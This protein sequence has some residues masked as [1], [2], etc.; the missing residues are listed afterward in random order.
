MKFENPRTGEVWIC[1]NP[2]NKKVIDGVSFIE[3]HKPDN[4]RRVWINRSI[5]V[6]KK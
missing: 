2:E 1:D 6:K 4:F 5:L 3:V